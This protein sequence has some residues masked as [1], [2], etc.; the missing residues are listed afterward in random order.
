M[1]NPATIYTSTPP[2]L[3][4][5]PFTTYT[6]PTITVVQGYE[7]QSSHVMYLLNVGTKIVPEGG[8]VRVLFD[9]A[10]FTSNVIGDCRV[11]GSGFVKST[12]TSSVLRC[13]RAL[14]GFVI[15]GFRAITPTASLSV[16]FYVKSLVAVTSS[17]ITVNVYGIYR[18]NTT[19]I[20]SAIVQS[21]THTSGSYPTNIQRI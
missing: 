14:D 2:T 20:S 9:S 11:V 18:D 4:L 7:V 17:D 19:S 12:L 15:A 6:T 3:T 8:E 16:Y 5:N 10:K 13:Y 1:F 21:L